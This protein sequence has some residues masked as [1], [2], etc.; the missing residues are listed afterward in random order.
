MR[1]CRTPLLLV[2]MARRYP[3]LAAQLL[4]QRCLLAYAR[5]GRLGMLEKLLRDEEASQREEDR[6][7]WAPLRR[8]QQA[9]RAS[10][11]RGVVSERSRGH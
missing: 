11:K 8:E 1:E 6:R 2:E 4:R 3:S 7:Y 5:S 9:L 10:R